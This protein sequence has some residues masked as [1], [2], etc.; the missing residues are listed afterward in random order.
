MQRIVGSGNGLSYFLWAGVD[1]LG[2]GTSW[3]FSLPTK[4]CYDFMEDHL[5]TGGDLVRDDH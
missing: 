2:Y 5:V 4:C 1:A 3:I